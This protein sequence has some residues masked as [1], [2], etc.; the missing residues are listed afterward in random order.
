MIEMNQGC[1]KPRATTTMGYGPAWLSQRRDEQGSRREHAQ[2]TCVHAA[3]PE[4]HV[5]QEGSGHMDEAGSSCAERQVN[6]HVMM[7]GIVPCTLK[8]T[9]GGGQR[10]AN[11]DVTVG[12]EPEY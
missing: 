3:R 2:E 1:L 6:E 10:P 11:M 7:V 9:G 8:P 12:R 5:T 4:G